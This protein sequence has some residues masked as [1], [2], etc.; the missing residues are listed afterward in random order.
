MCKGQ[1]TNFRAER[2]SNGFRYQ[3]GQKRCSYCSIYVNVDGSN[4]PCCSG[5]LRTKPRKSA[6]K[7]ASLNLK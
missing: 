4:C 3:I 5:R 2:V 7:R 6:S 1:C